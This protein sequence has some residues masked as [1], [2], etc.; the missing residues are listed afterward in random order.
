MG[1]PPAAAAPPVVALARAPPR[2]YRE[3]YGNDAYNT[4]PGHTAAYL[5]GYRFTDADGE[6][7]PTPATLRDQTIALSDRQSMSFL[8][9]ITGRDGLYEVVVIHH[10][11]R[12]WRP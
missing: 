8:A 6:V 1:V 9:L 2:S 7:I 4:A 3:L 12:Y 10:L 11:V 5:A